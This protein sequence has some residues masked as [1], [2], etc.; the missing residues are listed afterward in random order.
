[1]E[2][3][4]ENYN[5]GL[6]KLASVAEAS[7]ALARAA[8]LNGLTVKDLTQMVEMMANHKINEPERQE[9]WAQELQESKK[10][11]TRRKE[12]TEK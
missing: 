3:K 2:S 8:F 5:T 4:P 6:L 7:T 10:P 12:A 11:I 9:E 1:M